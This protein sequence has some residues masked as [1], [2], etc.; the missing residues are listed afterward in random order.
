MVHFNRGI[1][2]VELF[3]YWLFLA[4]GFEA[5]EG[6]ITHIVGTA[7]CAWSIY[8]GI[9]WHYKMKDG[10]GFAWAAIGTLVFIGFSARWLV[11]IP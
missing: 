6:K 7:A 8:N 9:K 3:C 2:A 1:L 4:S 10:E 5:V 11:A